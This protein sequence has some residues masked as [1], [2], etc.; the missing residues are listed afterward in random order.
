MFT[1]SFP[2]QHRARG[3]F[4]KKNKQ[5]KND[6]KRASYASQQKHSLGVIPRGARLSKRQVGDLPVVEYNIKVWIHS[7]LLRLVLGWLWDLIRT[8]LLRPKHSRA[9]GIL[10]CSSQSFVQRS[11]RLEF[12]PFL[13]GKRKSITRPLIASSALCGHDRPTRSES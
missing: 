13:V 12:S 2:H 4:T 7:I 9:L 1:T 5:D 6:K 8:S 10:S 3:V 11:C